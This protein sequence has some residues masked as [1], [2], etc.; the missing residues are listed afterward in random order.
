MKLTD[1]LS[2][3]NRFEVCVKGVMAI[4]MSSRMLTTRAKT[5]HTKNTTTTPEMCVA[6]ITLV[7][8]SRSEKTENKPKG[9]LPSNIVAIP[10]SRCSFLVSFVRSF[11]DCR[12][13]QYIRKFN[14]ASDTKG[15]IYITTKYIQ[16]M[17]TLYS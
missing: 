7:F 2:V 11:V 5:L 1:E 13:R 17:Y 9:F 12:I 16:V 10:I 8:V 15:T 14:T 3:T 4:D 6:K